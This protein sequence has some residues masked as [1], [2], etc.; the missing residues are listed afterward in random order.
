MSIIREKNA[1]LYVPK[2]LK[3]T[4]DDA[5][6]GLDVRVPKADRFRQEKRHL[7]INISIHHM[8]V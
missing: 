6:N 2:V 1:N 3:D 4:T 5:G 8:E 7:G